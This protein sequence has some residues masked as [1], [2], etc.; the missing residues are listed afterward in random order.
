MDIAKINSVKEIMYRPD[1]IRNMS[2][3]AHVD[4]GKC[5]GEKT[6]IRT[7]SGMT[8]KVKELKV[9]DKLM[10]DHNNAVTIQSI[11]RGRGMLYKVDQKCGDPYY[12][13]GN[14]ILCLKGTNMDIIHW[15][16]K[17]GHY[18]VRWLEKFS[19][20]E[21]FI[22]IK[23][24]K[25]LKRCTYYDTKEDAYVAAQEYLKDMKEN[26]PN[27]VGY[28]DVVEISV[29]EYMNLP[30]RVQDC[31]KGY[32]CSFD[33]PHKD[34]ELDPYV[35]G[36][37][38]GDG[39]SAG[40]HITTADKE[41]VDFFKDYANDNDLIFKEKSRKYRYTVTKQVGGKNTLRDQFKQYNLLKNKHI[42][43]DYKFN[44]R[45][46][47]LQVLAGFIDSDGHYTSANTY[48]IT[49]KREN[50]I[51]DLEYISR[52]LG[53]IVN[54]RK[55]IKKTCTNA[56]GGPKVGIYH[57][58]L[59][60]GPQLADVPC[61]I[62]RKK[63]VL[64][65]AAANKTLMTGIKI[66][67]DGVGDYVGFTLDD[68]QRHL[69]I[70]FT[71]SHNSTLSDSLVA[72][73]GL[74]NK[75]EAG[76][77]RIMD[78]R[79][80]EQDR[81]ITIKSSGITLLHEFK[82][83][84]Y[85]I[86]LIDSPGHVD[87]SSEVTSAIRV[88]D[89][90]LVVIDC[91][92]GV[93]VQTETV[94]R[95][96]LEE[97]VKPVVIINKVDR[98]IFELGLDPESIYQNFRK[99]IESV[100]VVIDMYNSGER[101]DLQCYADQGT[102]AFGSGYQAWAFTISQFAQ[103]WTEKLG[104]PVK[105]LEKYLWGDHFWNRKTKKFQTSNKNKK[106][107]TLKRGFCK[108][109]L[110]PIFQVLEVAKSGD[111]FKIRSF[112]NNV[113][114][115]LKPEELELN[116]KN[117]F[118]VIMRRWLP[119]AQALLEMIVIHLPSP[120]A[121]QKYRMDDLYQ[122]EKDDDAALAIQNCDPN[123]PLMIYVSKM[124]PDTNNRFY[125]FGRVFSGTV[126]TGM[127]ARIMGMNYQ[128]G[129]KKDLV[130]KSIQKTVLMM[131]NKAMSVPEV[132]CGNTVGLVGIDQWIKKSCTIS[133]LDTAHCIKP[134]KFSVSPVVQKAVSVKNAAE[135]A[136]LIEG[137][138]KLDK[139]DPCVQC[140][141]TDDGEN[142]IAGVGELH[143]EI[144]LKDLQDFIG[145]DV[146]LVVSDPIV[147]YREMVMYESSQ[148]C[149]SKSPNKHNRLYVT[150][151]P[152]SDE[153]VK[154][155]EEGIISSQMDT[156]ERV[157]ILVDKHGWNPVDAKK[158]WCFGPAGK[159]IEETGVNILVDTTKGV[160]YLNE[161]KASCIAAFQGVAEK[162]VLCREALRGIRFNI[163]DVQLHADTIHRGMGQIMPAMRSAMCGAI[164]LAEPRLAEP[165]FLVSISVPD[166]ALGG[167]YSCLSRRRGM[168][169]SE[170]RKEGTPIN[171][172]QAYLPVM[173][174]FGFTEDLRSQTS[175]KA[176][177]QCVFD[178]WEVMS[179]PPME[180][181]TKTNQILLDTRKRKDMKVEVPDISKFMDRL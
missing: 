150:C 122:G 50:L 131:G 49:Q 128:P 45:E 115:K 26:N 85:L 169:F 144:C 24:K 148:P 113:G 72:E 172:L 157:R 149:L 77:K 106:G 1:H 151:E 29:R 47:K 58:I 121:A 62:K 70:D 86:N 88:T 9:G 170:E 130:V 95:Q 44:S 159:T 152:L 177:P 97:N 17:K 109:I 74:I 69:L 116:G 181:G 112:V 123:G 18:K 143:M 162:G 167:V 38:L 60:S 75:D 180:E 139:S 54:V 48:E 135:I 165:V 67:E 101:G 3:V 161:I 156:K 56:P 82:G 36:Y 28:G 142:I 78:G 153:L 155:I 10:G 125:A 76:D 103:L 178:H 154:D 46:I 59:L 55:N 83:E 138:K 73:A 90:A 84:P 91:I 126:K 25:M 163:T 15:Y 57:S 92:E 51:D 41:I 94:L 100:N 64:N 129:S 80:D 99:N 52:S 66:T 175:G 23:K 140:I 133:N 124:I 63:Y 120:S 71:V 32:K 11:H 87:F 107:K 27:Y 114:V 5:L 104:I 141:C 14:H 8:K 96:S 21:K 33:H 31:F 176:F 19:I 146:K 168:V 108:F 98:L 68:N 20:K 37:W 136:K 12:V 89:G 65:E 164:L 7:V 40:T 22:P 127:K 110:E 93:C 174:S 118:K 117:L 111:E 102:V 16:E 39:D 13:N 160:Q 166:D 6:L 53:I 42:P 173:E 34:V 171:I 81:C 61:K 2:V 30:K 105:K 145:E 35:L 147:P 119:A 158:I 43:D 137:M 79:K 179:S 134:M 4:A 132:P